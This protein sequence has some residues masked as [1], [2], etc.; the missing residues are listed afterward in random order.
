MRPQ[1]IERQLTAG[2]DRHEM[3]DAFDTQAADELH[4][5]GVSQ[6]RDRHHRARPALFE[7]VRELAGPVAHVEP[8]DD[9]AD[10]CGGEVHLDPCRHVRRVERDAVAA[11]DAQ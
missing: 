8:D 9:A 6:L 5:V 1:F 10:R 4:V 3:L 11:L 7:D 2:A